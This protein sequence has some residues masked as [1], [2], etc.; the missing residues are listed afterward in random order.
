MN[1][2][3]SLRPLQLFAV[4]RQVRGR[5]SLRVQLGGGQQG[6]ESLLIEVMEA[7][8]VPGALERAADGLGDGVV[9]A[10]PLGMRKNDGDFHR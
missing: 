3:Q 2:D 1:N 6:I 9:E 10:V 5:L 7:D 4:Q 8:G